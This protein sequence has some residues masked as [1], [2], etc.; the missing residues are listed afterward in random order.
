[1]KEN[2]G[3]KILFVS[4]EVSPFAKTGG[5]ADVA[6]SLPGTLA[7]MGNDIRVVMPRYKTIKSDMMYLTDFAVLIGNRKET[8]I[9]KETE[10]CLK[11]GVKYARFPV[12]FIDNYNY[13]DREGIYCYSDDAE[14][15][16]FF[17]SAVLDMLPAVNFQPDIIHCND[18]HTGPICMLLCERYREQPFYKNIATVFTIHNLEYQGNFPRST[19][20]LFNLGEDIF[21]PEKVEFYGM[22]SF[23]KAGLVYS[24]I[25][26]TV[27]KR[28]AKEIQ[29][30]QYGEKLDG[31]LRKRSADLFGIVNGI[32]YEE[33]NPSTDRRIYKNYSLETYWDKKGN[34]TCLQKEMNLPVRDVPII[35][36]ISRLTGQKGLDIILDKMDA[37]LA[38]DVQFVLLGTGDEY[39][40]NAFKNLRIKYPDKFSAYIGFNTTLAQRIYAGS[41]MFL[42]PSRFEPCGLGQI[43]S[44]RYGTIPI[45]RATGGLADTI[46]D[47]DEDNEKGNGFVFDEYSSI[48]MLQAVERAIK[49]YNEKPE[50]WQQLVKRALSLDFSWDKPAKEYTEL[51]YLAIEKR[52]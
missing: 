19:F 18:W 43:I 37:L 23:M 36:L 15:F 9:V 13:F 34:K 41:D 25:I 22:F 7:L 50:V 10:V 48:E 3:L 39:F 6:G 28:Y 31:L 21:T 44:L 4:A 8:C 30:V 20:D 2:N 40:E 47:Y 33:F 24:D 42:M 38:H 5:L 35:S 26:N 51:Y 46:I 11:T 52:R 1:M 32:S 27:S 49:L 45:V 29:T 17:C 12:Y 14:R 16:G